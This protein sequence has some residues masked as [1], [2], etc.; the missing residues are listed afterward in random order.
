MVVCCAPP[1]GKRCARGSSAVAP[2]TLAASGCILESFA[3]LTPVFVHVQTNRNSDSK[4]VTV[5]KVGSP[6][7]LR[8]GQIGCRME[9][10]ASYLPAGRVGVRK[11]GLPPLP[12][13]I[14]SWLHHTT[15]GAS[16]PS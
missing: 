14:S 15:A 12:W 5:G 2:R 9:Q 8:Y 1:A 3:R 10:R 11:G 4:E 16:H 7:L 6:P 13:H